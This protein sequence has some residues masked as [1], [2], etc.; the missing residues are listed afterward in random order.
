MRLSSVQGRHK[1]PPPL[2]S[3]LL[4]QTKHTARV[5]V[6]S[7]PKA[8]GVERLAA[9]QPRL[10]VLKVVCEFL[11]LSKLHHVVEVLHVLHHGV[12]L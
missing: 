12:Q 4:S 8:S 2:P 5:A 7:S 6:S 1:G 9:L 11:V 10:Q 3:A